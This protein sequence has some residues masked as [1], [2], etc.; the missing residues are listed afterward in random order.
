MCLPHAGGTPAAYR[1]W[2]G[3]FS[4][5]VEVLAACYPG[6]QDRLAEPAVE[7]MSEMVD[8]L[9]DELLPLTDRPY[10]LFGHSMGASVAFELALALEHAHGTVPGALLLSGRLPPRLLTGRPPYLG[11]DEAIV[12]DVRRLGEASTAVLDDPE[13]RELVLP[14]I[15]ADYR[16]LGTYR[17]T[18]DGITSA[19]VTAYVGADDPDIDADHVLGWAEHTTAEFDHRVLPGDHFYLSAREETLTSDIAGRIGRL[20]AGTRS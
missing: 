13:L 3:R 14:A 2:P 16:L 15:R 19:P 8:A 20:G 1:G 5:R 12:A 9:V 11:G 10:V 18:L 4:E 6:R 17:P 7:S